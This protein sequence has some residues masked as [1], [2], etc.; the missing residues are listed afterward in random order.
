MGLGATSSWLLKM[1]YNVRY[2]TRKIFPNKCTRSYKKS[3]CIRY[4]KQ[5]KITLSGW[6]LRR[7][8]KR[9]TWLFRQRKGKSKQYSQQGHERGLQV[10]KGISQGLKKK[11]RFQPSSADSLACELALCC[12]EYRFTAQ[13]PTISSAAAYGKND[14]NPWYCHTLLFD[15]IPSFHTSILLSLPQCSTVFIPHT[16]VSL[17]VMLSAWRWAGARLLSWPPGPG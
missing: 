2:V 14:W 8:L 11:K 12:F 4:N 9:G 15:C 1:N 17:S 13:P 3:F 6:K 5:P 7:I 16:M 10:C